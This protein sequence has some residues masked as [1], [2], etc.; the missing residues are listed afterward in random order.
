MNAVKIMRFFLGWFIALVLLLIILPHVGVPQERFM[1]PSKVYANATG[2][3]QGVVIN[4][5]TKPSVNP[6]H[7]EDRMNFLD[8]EFSVAPPAAAG[9]GL[10]SD[11]KNKANKKSENPTKAKNL[12]TLKS[13]TLVQGLFYEQTEKGD[14]VQVR[15]EKT[16]PEINGIENPQAGQASVGP[17]VWYSMHW[18][19]WVGL[20]LVLGYFIMT[21]IDRFAT[22]QDL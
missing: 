6:F 11:A 10:N 18:L 14:A 21:I 1:P 4:K 3:A 22:R 5:Y 20:S 15:Y 12:I 17:N 7:T 19:R 9:V 16:F 13:T 2:H 8:Y